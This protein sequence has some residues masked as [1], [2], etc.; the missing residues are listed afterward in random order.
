MLYVE[1]DPAALSLPQLAIVGSR[2]PT[3]LGRDTARHFGAHLASAGLAIT[4]GLALGIDA[5][6]HWGALDADGRTIAVVGRGLDAIYPRENDELAR[7]IVE[8]QGALVTDLPVGTPPL[9]QNFPRRNRILSGLA[10]GTLVVEAAMQSGSL[11][12]AR[13]AGEQGREVFAMPG[14]IHNAL[15]RGCHKLLRQGAKLVETAD[16]IFAELAPILG[17]FAASVSREA[18]FEA[19]SSRASLDKDYEILLDA[20]GFEPA[21]LDAIV[22]RSGLKADAVASMLL[23][24]ELDGR[25]Q[26][27]PGGRY[28]RTLPGKV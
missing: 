7:R 1:G 27:Q 2:N 23:I 13:L 28:S 17:Q 19:R 9:K 14:S 12:T 24:L 15:A 20:L 5:A 3:A 8:R 6:A 22:V 16:D 18:H 25:I 11:I 26:Q 21:H 10:V 4:S